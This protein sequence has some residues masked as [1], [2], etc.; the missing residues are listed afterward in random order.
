V[1]IHLSIDQINEARA[2]NC[3]GL[4]QTEAGAPAM[5]IRLVLAT[6]RKSQEAYAAATAQV[7][8]ASFIQQQPIK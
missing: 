6:I 4:D 5:I 3:H 8:T 7:A 2:T 1:T